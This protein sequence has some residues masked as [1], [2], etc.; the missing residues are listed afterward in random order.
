MNPIDPLAILA[1]AV[2]TIGAGDPAAIDRLVLDLRAPTFIEAAASHPDQD[3]VFLALRGLLR[4]GFKAE[5]GKVAKAVEAR[6]KTIAEGAA[7]VAETQRRDDARRLASERREADSSGEWPMERTGPHPDVQESLDYGKYGPKPCFSNLFKIIRDDPRWNRRLRLNLLGSVVE[8]DGAPIES[9]P[10]LSAQVTEWVGDTYGVQ[11]KPDVTRDVIYAVAGMHSYH[12]VRDY[13]E[14]LPP[15]DGKE[16]ISRLLTEVLGIKPDD[17]EAARIEFALHQ[18][19][20]RRTLIGAVAR[21]MRP[22]CKMD[23]ALVLVGAQGGMKSTFLKVLFGAKF[24]GDSPIPIGD[25][26]A[27]IQLAACWGYECAEMESLNKR[28]AE[29]VKQWLSQADDLFRHIFERNARRWPRHSVIAG[30]TNKMEFLMD[31]TGSRRFWP[32][33]IPDDTVIDIALLKSL[34]DALWSEALAAW[35]GADAA[36]QRGEFPDVQQR[37]WFDR[38]ED[39]VRAEVSRRFE[40]SDVWDGIVMSWVNLKPTGTLFTIADI[41]EDALKMPKDRMGDPDKR[42]VGAILRR[43]GWT[44]KRARSAGGYRDVWVPVKPVG[45]PDPRANPA[46]PPIVGAYVPLD[47]DGVPH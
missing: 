29:E 14:A 30:T 41:L 23:T 27:A 46:T 7:L 8:V 4:P 38:E 28:T 2:V 22:G 20:L 39:A 9:E 36:I 34:R 15:W 13:L 19:F 18:K 37:W 26:N 44:D 1:E 5:G 12:P 17:T 3:A 33:P 25:K 32:V 43:H 35:R 40:V 10:L 11:Y 16:T 6:K 24:F 45:T 47:D 42:R 21:A 31:S